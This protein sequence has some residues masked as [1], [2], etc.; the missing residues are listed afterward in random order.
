M[1]VPL[2][3]RPLPL[4]LTS[5]ESAA[6]LGA[7]EKGH[8]KIVSAYLESWL[9]RK[10]QPESVGDVLEQAI[11]LTLKGRR[12]QHAETLSI[13]LAAWHHLCSSIHHS[14]NAEKKKAWH[15]HAV[16]GGNTTSIALLS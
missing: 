6:F 7:A 16:Q 11:L 2:I 1:R 9:T 3:P 14:D 15:H 10:L 12:K 4:I 13:L 5:A 8:D